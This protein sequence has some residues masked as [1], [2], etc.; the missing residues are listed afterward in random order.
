MSTAKQV[1]T[2]TAFIFILGSAESI[3]DIICKTLGV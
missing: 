2:V 3:A 1:L